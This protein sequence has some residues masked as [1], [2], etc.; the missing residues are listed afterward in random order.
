MQFKN[1]VNGHIES[2][3]SP[4]L[5]TILFGGFYF[6]AVGLWAPLI[7]WLLLSVALF[8]AMGPPAVV[9]IMIMNVVCALLSTGLLR[10]SYL[11]KGWIEVK[12][13]DE[14]VAPQA[15]YS[16]PYRPPSADAATPAAAPEV[17]VAPPA[18]APV[19]TAT[20]DETRRC[21]FCAEDIR[22]AAIKC[23]HCGSTVEPVV[24]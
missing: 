5:W 11:R 17:A 21:P 1:P 4:W 2:R 13:G 14:P 18:A 8:A 23:K 3:S 6:I 12:K 24:S 16:E 9:L 15:A 22:A 19:V 20:G 7:I 10:A